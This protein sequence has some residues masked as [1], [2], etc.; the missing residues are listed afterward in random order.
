MS[1][2]Q[3]ACS[4]KLQRL[5]LYET[6]QIRKQVHVQAICCTSEFTDEEIGI[7]DKTVSAQLDLSEEVEA[8]LY[9]ICGY[10]AKKTQMDQARCNVEKL[11]P[12][13]EFTQLVSR[14]RLTFPSTDLFQ[15]SR[16][17][18]FAFSR[19]SEIQ[20]FPPCCNRV[21][22]LFLFL[23][24]STDFDFL[25]NEK[26]CQKMAN[27]FFKGFT[28]LWNTRLAPVRPNSSSHERRK[29]KLTGK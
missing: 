17:S 21:R 10:V 1:V 7:L 9:F 24:T 27:T 26:V 11:P 3:V 5:K 19:L 8:T 28:Q 23:L 29:R 12:E 2:E 20:S 15:F 18:Y 6:L 4:L 13:S 25:C 14:G 16:L 22:R